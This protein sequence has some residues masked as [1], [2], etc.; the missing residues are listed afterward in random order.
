[1]TPHW[2]GWTNLFPS[3]NFTAKATCG[4]KRNPDY[5][6]HSHKPEFESELL[7]SMGPFPVNIINE[8]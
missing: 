4:S 8:Q 7:A 6:P 2:I 1:M 5:S 3:H